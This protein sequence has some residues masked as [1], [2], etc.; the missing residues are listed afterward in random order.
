MKKSLF[1]LTLLLFLI[2]A[3]TKA[4]DIVFKSTFHTLDNLEKKAFINYKIIFD[5]Q[6][7]NKI[8]IENL[9]DKS[10]PITSLEVDFRHLFKSDLGPLLILLN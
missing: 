3:N 9:D 6:K 10:S 4:Q 1:C 2:S 7:N 8:L 5:V